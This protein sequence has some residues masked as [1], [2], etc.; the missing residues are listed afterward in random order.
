MNSAGQSSWT[1]F[2]NPFPCPPG[3]PEPTCNHTP[4]ELI[5]L[6]DADAYMQSTLQSSAWAAFTVVQ[7]E[8]ALK[9]A[10]NALR[11]LEWCTE[12]PIRNGQVLTDNYVA[13]ASELA[14]ALIKSASSVFGATSQLPEPV[15]SREKMGPFERDFASPAIVASVLP[16]DKRVGSRSP[17]VLRTYP[18]LLDLIGLWVQSPSSTLVPIF[19]G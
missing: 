5:T 6:A 12:E 16:R 8:Q 19:R 17:V 4:P 18:W 11:T 1:R 9:S 15:V 2:A 13:A 14:L 3:S 7:K 10:Q